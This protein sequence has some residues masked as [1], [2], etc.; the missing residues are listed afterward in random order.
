MTKFIILALLGLT[1]CGTT[2]NPDSWQGDDFHAPIAAYN[3]LALNDLEAYALG[4]A[5]IDNCAKG[6]TTCEPDLLAYDL[7]MTESIEKT[8]AE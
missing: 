1:A 8:L 7:E 2:S 4:L 5:N 3:G 6:A